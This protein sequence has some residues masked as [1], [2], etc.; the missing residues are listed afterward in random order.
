MARIHL[1]DDLYIDAV[2]Y[3]SRANAILGIRDSGKTWTGTLIAE[4]LFE[5][6]IPFIA[7]DPIGRWRFLKVPSRTDKNARGFPVVVAGGAAPDLPLTPESAPKIVRAAMKNRIS[8]VIDLYS[9][10][11]SK[12][13]WRKIV[14][15][16]IEVMMYE[17]AAYGMRHVFLE[18]AAE[19]IPQRVRDGL[20]YAEVEQLARM[21]GN[22][23]L[24]ITIINQRAEEVNKAVLE[25]CDNLLLHR[26]RGKNSIKSLAKW[27]ELADVKPPKEVANSLASMP[28]GECWAWLRDQDRPIR[29]KVAAKQSYDPDRRALHEFSG[30]RQPP[31]TADVSGFVATLRE[32]L[33]QPVAAPPVGAGSKPVAITA[34]PKV[35]P[36]IK[37]KPPEEADVKESEA[38]ALIAE[39][40]RLK[41]D[42]DAARREIASLTTR[43]TT[44]HSDASIDVDTIVN[45]V[46]RRAQNDPALLRVSADRPEIEVTHKRRV[47]MADTSKQPGLLALM[48]A[49]GFFEHSVAGVAVVQEL[50]RRGRSVHHTNVY[51][52]LNKLAED[53]FL[54][55]E[56]EGYQAVE[57]MK[58]NIREVE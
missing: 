34:A 3:A 23:G 35:A 29:I 45:E 22:V 43:K 14:R 42:L 16:S 19:F 12:S 54:T 28:T 21:G 7:F 5:A 30:T 50:K 49:E 40:N 56:G 2:Q 27:M 6:G 46:L 55:R 48:I 17:N 18:E 37:Q 32:Q 24:G 13:D 52:D 20:T 51:R 10:G 38:R 11:L 39:N 36:T 33:K 31:G 9:V 57:G 25:L 47:I 1:G 4:Q 15:T 53:G 58:V 8:L 26:Q 41:G 44:Q